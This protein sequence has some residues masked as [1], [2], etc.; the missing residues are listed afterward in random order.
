MVNYECTKQAAIQASYIV[1]CLLVAPI[2]YG[3][4]VAEEKKT[5]LVDK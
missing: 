3:R 4:L 1:Y 2:S 5:V